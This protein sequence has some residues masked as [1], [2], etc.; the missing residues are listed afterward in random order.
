MSMRESV[1]FATRGVVSNK[2][3]ALDTFADDLRDRIFNAPTFYNKG[4]TVQAG[5]TPQRVDRILGTYAVGHSPTRGQ[6][7]ATMMS[8]EDFLATIH[9]AMGLAPEMEIPDREGR[10]QL[11]KRVAVGLTV[12]DAALRLP[13]N[14]I[15]SNSHHD[16]NRAQ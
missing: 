4:A 12:G 2:Q 8:P 11:Q 10:P 16:L 5:W 7:Y 15:L 13:K 3:G 6:A 9:H 1:R 14:I